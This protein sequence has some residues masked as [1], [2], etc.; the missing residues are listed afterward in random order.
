MI[1]SR[2]NAPLFQP[3]SGRIERS[4]PASA[5]LVV[6]HLDHRAAFVASQHAPKNP[7]FQRADF[8]QKERPFDPKLHVCI[9]W[10]RLVRQEANPFPAE[11]QGSAVPLMLADGALVTEPQRHFERETPACSTITMNPVCT[12]HELLPV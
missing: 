3:L 5:K 10:G 12:G 11:I 2:D 4:R 7:Q 6:I 1:P 9:N 8:L